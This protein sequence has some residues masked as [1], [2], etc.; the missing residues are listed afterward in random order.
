MENLSRVL[1]QKADNSFGFEKGGEYFSFRIGGKV[2]SG[3]LKEESS[4]LGP[5]RTTEKFP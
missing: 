2:F 5:Q 4:T 3:I 1:E